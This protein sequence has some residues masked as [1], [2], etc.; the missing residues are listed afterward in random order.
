MTDKFSK[1]SNNRLLI[2]CIVLIT[3]LAYANSLKNSFVWDDYIVVVENDFIKSWDNFYRL[4]DKSYLT[5][6]SDIDYLGRR[7]IGSGE[8]LY[9]PV[10]TFSYFIDFSI[11]KLNPFGFHLTNLLLHII[12]AILLF[13]LIMLITRIKAVAFLTSLLFA[14]HPVTTETVDVIAFRPN[15]LSLMFFLSAFI[16]FIKCNQLSGKKQVYVYL[17]SLGSFLLAIFSKEM[18]L[19]FPIILLC[20]DYFIRKIPGNIF[21]HLK[22]YY[23]GYAGVLFFCFLVKYIAIGAVFKQPVMDAMQNLSINILTMSKVIATYIQWLVFPFNVHPTLP[24]DPAFIA[25]SLFEPRVIISMALI[26]AMLAIAIKARNKVPLVSFG[27]FWFFIALIPVA[28][29]FY[30]LTN[31]MAARYLYLPTIGF[32]LVVSLLLVKCYGCMI[33]RITSVMLQ[34]ISVTAVI[35]AIMSYAMFTAIRNFAFKNNAVFWM[36]MVENYP[37]NPLAHSS[38]AAAFNERGL[39]DKAIGEYKAALSLAPDYAKDYSDLGACYY[40]KGMFDAAIEQ[41]KMA[42]KLDPALI[43]AFTNLGSVFGDKGLYQDAIG[44]FNKAIELDT[45]SLDAYN[46]LGVT[47]ARIGEYV[48]AKKNWEKVL[49]IAP[50]NHEAQKNLEKLEQMG[51]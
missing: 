9:R 11:W 41:F 38:L 6:S 27:I 14:I 2:L 24:D 28:N 12:N 34:R 44:C 47:Y 26:A 5:R 10:S 16:L 51:Y 50:K 37:H 19:I 45:K 13:S 3:A 40:K 8:F 35:I 21:T 49:E 17:L 30:P 22:K 7:D 1:G 46:G 39:F 18:A 29:I 31:Y 33:F 23:M 32:V 43:S 20:Y 42:L 15:L 36:E 4:F 25:H 48:R